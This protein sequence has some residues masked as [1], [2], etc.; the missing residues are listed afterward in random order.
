VESPQQLHYSL[1]S[2][3][4]IKGHVAHFDDAEYGKLI[5]RNTRIFAGA[6]FAVAAALAFFVAPVD[7]LLADVWTVSFVVG[8]L[9]FVAFAKPIARDTYRRR[10]TRLAKLQDIGSQGSHIATIRDDGLQEQFVGGTVLIPWTR[11][12]TIT[13]M[14]DFYLIHVDRGA[15]FLI[16]KQP[17]PRATAAFIAA[18]REREA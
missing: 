18:V 8:G 9:L 11:L 3:D 4:Q 16:P 10:L 15:F 13:E 2:K 7:P 17:D 12:K 5:V 6:T 1:T 14:D